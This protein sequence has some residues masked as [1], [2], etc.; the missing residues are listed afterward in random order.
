MRWT[1][2]MVVMGMVLT[3]CGVTAPIDQNVHNNTPECFWLSGEANVWVHTLNVLGRTVDQNECFELDSCHGG[4]GHSNGG[5]Y[6]WALSATA[7]RLPWPNAGVTDNAPKTPVVHPVDALFSQLK[8]AVERNDG[9]AVTQT[10]ADLN[11]I[12]DKYGYFS[13]FENALKG[14]H[15]NAAKALI[16]AVANSTEINLWTLRLIAMQKPEEYNEARHEL[17]KMLIASS[18]FKINQQEPLNFNGATALHRTADYGYLKGMELLVK[19]GADLN[20]KNSD[21][22]TPL[23]YAVSGVSPNAL[24]MT[25]LLL[26]NGAHV[27]VQDNRMQ[28]PLFKTVFFGRGAHRDALIALLL[29]HKADP[30]IK[31]NEGFSPK[32]RLGRKGNHR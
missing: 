20:I 3:G 1:L 19:R 10:I 13:Y 26:Q 9:S 15:Y 8:A 18:G 22:A 6:K 17:F 23:H 5:C 29:A 28:T 21:G 24:E 27:N 2:S 7:D 4:K 12:S 30:S 16:K 25:K 32:E 14:G 31:D 11:Q